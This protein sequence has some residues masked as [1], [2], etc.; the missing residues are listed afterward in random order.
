MHCFQVDLYDA[1]VFTANI[2][3]NEIIENYAIVEGVKEKIYTE[4]AVCSPVKML[5]PEI[6]DI[7]EVCEEIFGIKAPFVTYKFAESGDK[8]F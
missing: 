5:D 7:E 4:T 8:Y 3:N 6:V 2:P 1:L